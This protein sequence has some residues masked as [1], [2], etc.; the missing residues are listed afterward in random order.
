MSEQN[1]DEIIEMVK[2]LILKKAKLQL[3]NEVNTSKAQVI[4]EIV[5]E[6]SRKYDI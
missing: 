5:K 1:K 3:Y 6:V 4:Q 2:G